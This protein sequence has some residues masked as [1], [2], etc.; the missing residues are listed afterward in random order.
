MEGETQILEISLM[1]A[2]DLKTP[3]ANLHSMQTY[4]LIWIEPSLKLR[5]QIDRLGGE[6]PTWNDKFLF[7]VDKDFVTGETS[8]VSVEIYAVGYIKDKLI[9]TVRFLLSSCLQ[10][11]ASVTGIGIPAF[12]AVQIRRPSGRFHGVLN[13][14]VT[15]YKSSDFTILDGLS[16]ICFRDLMKRENDRRWRRLS[17][18]GSKKSEKSSGG[19][20]CDFSCGDSID[21]DFS[22]GG[23]STSSSSSTTSTVLKEWNGGAG[24][25]EMAGKKDLKSDGGGSLCWLMLQRKIHL[26]PSDQNIQFWAE[27][28]EKKH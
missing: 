7:R 22:D 3:S 10:G 6:N 1:S 5:T 12:T 15:V 23:D 28:L 26:S 14:A 25:A 8:A 16:A 20:S 21:L 11:G 2:Q 27:S 13:I 4:A 17:R 24:R 9:G 19:E 18:I